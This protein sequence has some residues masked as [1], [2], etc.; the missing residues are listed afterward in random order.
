MPYQELIYCYHYEKTLLDPLEVRIEDIDRFT[1]EWEGHTDFSG[2]QPRLWVAAHW[3]ASIPGVAFIAARRQ[4]RISGIATAALK[5]ETVPAGFRHHVLRR[6]RNLEKY[7]Y[8]GHAY[9]HEES[10]REIVRA[11]RRK[12]DMIVI[13]DMPAINESAIYLPFFGAQRGFRAGALRHAQRNDYLI[14][15]YWVDYLG[16]DRMRVW[17]G[18]P[19]RASERESVEKAL[20]VL[21]H[22]IERQPCKWFIFEQLP[23]YPV[24]S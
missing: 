8:G 11:F 10:P 23:F 3:G 21:L 4:K 15:P 13:F 12:E 5:R 16:R 14:Q 18:E 17:C 19:V 2:D 6:Y 1:I 20:Q 22:K 9:F 24:R 7:F